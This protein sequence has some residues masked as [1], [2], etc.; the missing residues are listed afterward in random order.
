V[1]E[2]AKDILAKEE[3]KESR[4]IDLTNLFTFTIDGE[5]AKDLDDAISLKKLDNGNFKLFVH[6]A[7]VAHFVR[8]KSFLDEEA[9]KRGTSLYLTDRVIPMLP[10]EISNGVCS[11]NPHEK[12][13]T[14][15]CE[16][17]IDKHGKTIATR[18]YESTIKSDFR[19]S[20]KQ[21]EKIRENNFEDTEL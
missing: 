17:D 10:S 4:R 7:D 5:D 6:I 11:I 1:L 13:L 2:E 21:V 15:T 8:E 19:L 14:L 12:K 9:L 20:Y 3:I 16:M 18:V